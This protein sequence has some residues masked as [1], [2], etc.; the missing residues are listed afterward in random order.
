MAELVRMANIEKYYGSVH[1]LRDV[2]FVV[3]EREIVGL[4][5][6]NGAGKSTLI[7]VLSGAVPVTSGTITI[8]GRDGLD[9]QHQRR[10][11][12]RHRD[13]LPGLRPRPPALD[14]PQPLPRPRAGPRPAPP[15]PPRRADDERGRVP[16]PP[17]RRHLQ[18]HPPDHPDR[19]ALRR[20]APVGR[21]RPRHALRQ[22]PHRPR[23]A[24]QQPRRR[25]DPRGAQLRPRRPRLA[26][27]P[28]SSSPT[29]S[30]T[31]SRWSTASS[32]CAAAASSP[33]TSTRRPP[34]SSASR[35]SSPA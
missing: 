11:R 22:R 29:T 35:R 24:D 4:L 33:T 27:T 3:N 6:D 10:H 16:A 26:A 18:E 31:S 20:R 2:T 28:A 1:A 13:H 12:Q 34:P 9:P 17:P 7:K 19:L 23:R 30:T 15:R 5:G 21:H 25:R 32:S 8:K 14:R